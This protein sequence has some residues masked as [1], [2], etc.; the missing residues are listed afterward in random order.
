MIM[1]EYFYLI[2]NLMQH[3]NI[4]KNVYRMN[5]EDIISIDL[6]MTSTKQISIRF[7]TIFGS[8]HFR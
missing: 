2:R 6:N 8:F 1:N 5:R 7:V 3:R 4:F